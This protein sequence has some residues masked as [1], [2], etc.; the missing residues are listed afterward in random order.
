[1]LYP[2]RSQ[3]WNLDPRESSR[4]SSVAKGGCISS[5]TTP[6]CDTRTPGLWR[7][8]N[9][10]FVTDLGILFFKFR[11]IPLLFFLFLLVTFVA[12]SS[13]E[14]SRGGKVAY[15]L[16]SEEK[17]WMEP[18]FRG[19]MLQNQAI[20]TLCGS[21]PMTMI[22]LESE[23]ESPPND[24]LKSKKLKKDRIVMEDYHLLRNWE[25]WEQVKSRF[26]LQRYA[27]FKKENSE[28][29]KGA[30]I[31]FADLAKVALALQEHY[32]TFKAKTCL[33]FDPLNESLRIE[34]GSEFWNK[35]FDHPALLGILLGYGV[36]NSFCF[37][38]KYGDLQERHQQLS[39][40]LL[41][42]FSDKPQS[43]KATLDT[44]PL[45][46]FASFSQGEDEVIEKYK[47]EREA[48]RAA[49]EDKDFLT[50]TLEK[51]TLVDP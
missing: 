24:H 2:D 8:P 23:S 46:I 17:A 20:Y 3:I 28:D 33:D 27:F 12:S 7:G 26:R 11:K 6:L 29:A 25:H 50:L 36:R 48:I 44:L 1:M 15:P 30:T 41:F 47:R 35:V 10:K 34:Q 49:Y 13:F 32:N 4:G 22:S 31:Y 18:F 19:I 40:S 42:Q 21:K 37:L 38:W 43:G 9:S 51:L 45:P 39:E 14:K 5:N 16:S